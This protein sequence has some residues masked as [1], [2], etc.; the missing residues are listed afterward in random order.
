MQQT[1]QEENASEVKKTEENKPQAAEESK[2]IGKV[3][4]RVY[5]SYFLAGGGWLFL[6]LL[7]LANI[8]TQ[9]LFSGSDYWLA[10]WLVI[11]SKFN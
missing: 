1:P 5:L 2:S 4:F 6:I 9:V 3:G 10:Y 7:F 11:I 8:I